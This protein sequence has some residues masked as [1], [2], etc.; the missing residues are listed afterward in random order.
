MAVSA[1]GDGSLQMWS[2][3]DLSNNNSQPQMVYNEHE[4]EI[5][6]VDWCK[7]RLKQQFLSASWDCTLKLWDP[8]RR[9]SVST[10][11][12][13]AVIAYSAVFSPKIPNMFASVGGDGYLKLWSNLTVSRP[14]FS[15]KTH[16]AEVLT[17]DWNK[18]N[19]NL[20]ATGGADGLIR[21][22]DVRNLGDPVM[23][24]QGHE[25]AV[26]KIQFSPFDEHSLASVGY[27]FTTR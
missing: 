26:R 24:L 8:N 15:V 7:T 22:F 6:S 4:K 19:Q 13:H 18:F 3:N 11:Y 17:C 14:V 27:D 16:D 2:L 21:V 10:Y 20:L 9:E 23:E 5:Y 25:L 12:A 1:S